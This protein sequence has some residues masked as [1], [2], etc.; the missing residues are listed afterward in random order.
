MTQF[1]DSIPQNAPPWLA[2]GNAER[3]LYSFG[4]ALD[5]LAEKMNQATRA[6]MP[7]LADP[8][9]IPYQAEDRRLVQ[10]TAESDDAFI[11]RMRGFLDTWR[12]A[13]SRKSVM[14]QV[15]AYLTGLQPGVPQDWPELAIVG[16]NGTTASWDVLTFSAAQGAAPAHQLVTPSNWDVD[17]IVAPW[18]AWLILYMPLVTMA[19]AGSAA[20][21]SGT[22]GSGVPGVGSGF[23]TITGLTGLTGAEQYLTLSGTDNPSNSGTFQISSFVSN[24][25]VIIANPNAD[26]PDANNGSIV[27]TTGSYPFL[28]PAPVWGALNSYWG[29]GAWGVVNPDGSSPE[30]TLAS[31]RA[32]VRRWK[33]S[34]T[35]YP[36]FIISFGGADGTAGSEFSPLSSAGSGNPDGTWVVTGANDGGVWVPRRLPPNQFTSFIDG[37]GRYVDCSI[38]NQT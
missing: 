37:T 23:A 12:R 34:G 8:T 2:T 24:S 33:S 9:A 14:G 30:Q 36:N 22:G 4:L 16:S 21:V 31:I 1:R 27:W 20:S 13:G 5:L 17:G 35:Y 11:D 38:Q 25:S 15:Q 10:G 28:R 32:L 26:D 3:Y 6:H 18:R 19:A 29:S 7:G